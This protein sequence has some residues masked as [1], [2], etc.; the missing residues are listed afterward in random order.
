MKIRFVSLFLLLL[1]TSLSEAEV[2]H[3]WVEPQPDH[4]FQNGAVA[5]YPFNTYT[6]KSASRSESGGSWQLTGSATA[7][8]NVQAVSPR[9]GDVSRKWDA[10]AQLRATGD[11][12]RE[13]VDA[14]KT[15]DPIWGN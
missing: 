14:R 9:S 10:D 1:L 4:A 7:S 15:R 12:D 13:G 11:R 2:L 6:S 5:E 3:S 8:A